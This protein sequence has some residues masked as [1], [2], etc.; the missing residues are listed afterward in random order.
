MKGS[1][2]IV[3][4]DPALTKALAE[5][6]SADGFDVAQCHSG[7]E[8]LWRLEETGFDLVV[9]DIK[10]PGM[11]GLEFCERVTANFPGLPV[12]IITGV[13][14][15]QMAIEAVRVGA[16]D[17][18][19]KPIDIEHLLAAL[20][21]A[22]RK[23]LLLETRLD[24]STGKPAPESPL[25]AAIVGDSHGTQTAKRLAAQ[26][27]PTSTGILITGEAGTGKRLLAH[28]IFE[29]SK[30]VG[31]A[32][33]VV[34]HCEGKSDDE[35]VREFIG[36]ID[37]P[38][39]R[40]NSSPE[41]RGTRTVYLSEIECLSKRAQ[42]EIL[43]GLERSP[44]RMAP[45][46]EEQRIRFM[47][48]SRLGREELLEKKKF[49]PELLL[50]LA[51]VTIKLPP[52]RDRGGDLIMLARHYLRAFSHSLGRSVSGLT[53]AATE[54]LLVYSWPGNVRELAAAMEHAVTLSRFEYVRVEDLPD[55]VK[56]YRNI[57]LYQESP[58]A[59]DFVPLD[60]LERRHIISVLKQLG[61]NKSLAAR[62]LGLDR[63]TLYR[64][65]EQYGL[66]AGEKS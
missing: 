21:K 60:E 17:F 9:A 13:A 44:L 57:A 26:V 19:T 5:H 59:N 8:A 30:P 62:A 20:N 12:F 43:E 42:R 50:D 61:G 32:E 52:L 37:R 31:Q 53:Q 16:Y 28:T 14:T 64:K 35:I 65:L 66:S 38:A 10:M 51:S 22:D 29:L 55:A 7:E 27:A 58:T 54:R 41:E 15:L 46:P 48:A 2:L 45:V 39:D 36:F 23:R 4:D 56:A 6:L 25:L 47:L 3:D 11:N 34:M 24:V 33:L 63:R 18:V 49:R 40:S 1:V